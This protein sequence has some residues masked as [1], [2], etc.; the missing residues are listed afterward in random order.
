M[1]EHSARFFLIGLG[2][3]LLAACGDTELI[4]LTKLGSGGT[5]GAAGSAGQAGAAGEGGSSGTAGS[6]A[7]G[8][9]GSAG[10]GTSGTGGTSGAAGN[11]AGGVGGA[12]GS[13]GSAGSSASGGSAGA[14]ASA[15]TGGSAGTAGSAGSGGSAG[16]GGG[17][18]TGG[19]GGLLGYD[20]HVNGGGFVLSLGQP[21]ATLQGLETETWT[22]QGTQ[23]VDCQANFQVTN[24]SFT[25]GCPTCDW[26]WDCDL[27]DGAFVSGDCAALG[28]TAG[29][30]AFRGGERYG[31]R[32]IDAQNAELWRW[33]GSQ[34]VQ[35]GTLFFGGDPADASDFTWIWPD[36]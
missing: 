19:T 22:N 17:A 9:S 18:G 30:S 15:S 36:P 24:V 12:A 13:G 25:S 32:H 7:G 20:L 29:G 28:Y 35:V 5:A 27:T 21:G 23:N 10:T 14:G 34:W 6:S 26:G 8:N 16:A 4:P 3:A 2:V 11:S 31:V 1:T 33:N